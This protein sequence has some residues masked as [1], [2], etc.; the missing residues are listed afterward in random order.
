[1]T[2][3]IVL[4]RTFLAVLDHGGFTSAA[5]ALHKTQS[6]V[7]QHVQRLEEAVGHPLLERKRRKVSLT[8]W[9][10]VLV[11]YAEALVSLND[12][13]ALKLKRPTVA[14]SIRLGILEDFATGL[15]P[16][17]LHRFNE[18]YP[19]T[20]LM[21]RSAMTAELNRELENGNLDVIVARQQDTVGSDDLL[22]RESLHWVGSAQ[23]HFSDGVLPLVLFPPECVYRSEVLERVRASGREWEIVYTSTSLAG[24]QAA[25]A[26]GVGIGVLAQSAILP[27]LTIL[28]NAE[29]L[30]AL[31]DTHIVLRFRTASERDDALSSLGEYLAA[32]VPSVATN[33]TRLNSVGTNHFIRSPSGI[34]GRHTER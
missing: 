12:E 27:E 5:R 4:L 6:T 8:A 28:D 2:F 10:E 20:K 18:V 15:L 34:P 26:A 21:V 9:G 24:V 3:D 25:I 22:W 7:S 30:P 23:R 13:A 32:A 29:Y 33:A 1:M 11:V 14:G 31:P 19:A 16:A 17:A